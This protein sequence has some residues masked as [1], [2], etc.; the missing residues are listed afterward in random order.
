MLFLNTIFLD[1]LSEVLESSC[2]TGLSTLVFLETGASSSLSDSARACLEEG[3]AAAFTFEAGGFALELV[4]VDR[5]LLVE[6]FFLGGMF[7]VAEY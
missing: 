6:A 2:L 4:L 3:F 1:T 5:G 7:S